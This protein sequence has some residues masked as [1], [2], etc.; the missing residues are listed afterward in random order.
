VLFRN[1][2]LQVPGPAY[3]R[4]DDPIPPP[5]YRKIN[6][7]DAPGAIGSRQIAWACRNVPETK[8]AIAP[9]ATTA[10]PLSKS[11]A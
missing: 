2:F 3:C 10:H 6:S 9:H 8:Q 11:H 1:S 4:S 7:G 5:E